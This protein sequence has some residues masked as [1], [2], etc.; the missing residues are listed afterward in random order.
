MIGIAPPTAA[1]YLNVTPRAAAIAWSRGPCVRKKL[2]VRGDNVTSAVEGA[3]DEIACIVRS[4][5]AFD[6]KIDVWILDDAEGIAREQAEDAARHH[7]LWLRYARRWSATRSRSPPRRSM[8]ARSLTR[9]TA[10][11]SG[12]RFRSRANRFRLLL[13]SLTARFHELA[14]R[15]PEGIEAITRCEI[16]ER[17]PARR[18]D[19]HFAKAACSVETMSLS[20]N[21]LCK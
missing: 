2:L 8:A 3:L 7:G 16:A 12:P 20:P 11:F 10:T 6:H 4:A 18:S 21:A 13:A 14:D 5:D 19:R 15:L 9:R 1:S 17:S